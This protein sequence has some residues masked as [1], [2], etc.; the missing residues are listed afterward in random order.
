MEILKGVGVAKKIIP[1]EWRS[2][3]QVK[4][5]K[6]FPQK[7]ILNIQ[8]IQKFPGLFSIPMLAKNIRLIYI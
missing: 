3:R 4:Q 6:Q 5:T 2:S 7:I 8:R 1:K